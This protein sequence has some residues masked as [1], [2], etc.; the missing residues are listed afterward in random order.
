MKYEFDYVP[1]PDIKRGRQKRN[2]KSYRHRNFMD[3]QK[4]NLHVK[5][6]KYP[7]EIHEWY[8]KNKPALRQ[9]GI[10]TENSFFIHLA[11]NFING[12]T[13]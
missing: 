12:E 13:N 10:T 8:V 2:S 3:K 1:I 5:I 6:F 7:K 9:L 4:N 11:N